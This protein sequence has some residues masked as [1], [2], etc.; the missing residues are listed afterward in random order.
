MREALKRLAD[1]LAL[2]LAFPA[3]LCYW[4]GA[5]AIGARRAFPAWSQLI[6]LQPGLS[7]DYLRRAFYRWTLPRCGPG[8]VVSFGTVFSHPSV[9]I[10]ARAYLGVFCCLGDVAIEDDVLV[11]SHVSIMNGSRQHGIESLEVPVREQPGDWPRV[12]IGRDT[13]IGDRAIVMAD[14]GCHCVV[15]A[16]SVV[17]QPVPDYAIVVG[18]PAR[19][20]GYRTASG[21]IRA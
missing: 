12:T 9:E 6:S 18:S 4:L 15:G 1:G 17:T 7:G 14:I 2:A 5:A 8:S 21:P 3:A 13:W 11:G 16:G 10:G 20:T 19:V